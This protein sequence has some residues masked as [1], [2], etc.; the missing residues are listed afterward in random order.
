MGAE[1][2]SA[3]L[4]TFGP[5]ELSTPLIDIARACGFT[6]TTVWESR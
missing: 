6:V 5:R 3:F 1:K 4:L 2:G